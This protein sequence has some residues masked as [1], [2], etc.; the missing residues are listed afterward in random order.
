MSSPKTSAT[1]PQC[2]GKLCGH[3]AMVSTEYREHLQQHKTVMF[4]CLTK[5]HHAERH[6]NTGFLHIRGGRD[7]RIWFRS[8][9]NEGQDHR[10]QYQYYSLLKT[11]N[12][13]CIMSAHNS[14]RGV[15]TAAR[16]PAFMC[17]GC[18][19]TYDASILSTPGSI[20]KTTLHE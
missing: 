19:P 9:T 20:L 16:R 4:L 18:D 17:T 3:A 6:F 13:L 11:A 7:H 12:V 10:Y 1:I 15:N 8:D 14:S 2:A 5:L